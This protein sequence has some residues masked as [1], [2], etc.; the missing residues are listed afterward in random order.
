MGATAEKAPQLHESI[1]KWGMQRLKL[2][3]IKSV[4]KDR[5][6]TVLAKLFD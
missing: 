3:T 4:S 2:V 5:H 1:Y 6:I